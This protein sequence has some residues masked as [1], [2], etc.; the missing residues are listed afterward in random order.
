MSFDHVL[1]LGI[2]LVPCVYIGVFYS[3]RSALAQLPGRVRIAS[4]VDPD[5]TIVYFP[6]LED[7][8]NS[9]GPPLEM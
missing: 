3:N 6:G 5:F 8:I 2:D 7:L 4:D 9:V 1:T